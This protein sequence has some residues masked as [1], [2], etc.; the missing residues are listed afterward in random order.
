MNCTNRVRA[1]KGANRVLRGGS[2]GNNADNCRCVYR[3]RN[4]PDDRDKN[5]GF[6]LFSSLCG[7]K[8]LVHG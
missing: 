8:R 3:N 7:R 1:E 6:R 5:V 4:D 2:W